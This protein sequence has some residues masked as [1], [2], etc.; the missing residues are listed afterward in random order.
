MA[1][2]IAD[3]YD[4]DATVLEPSEEEAARASERGLHVVL[5][6][7]EEL[8]PADKYDVVLLCQ[9][10]DHL[11]D[12]RG[13]LR[14]LRASL[15]EGGLFFMDVVLNGPLK[16]DHPF[17]LSEDACLLYLETAG[18]E[19]LTSGPAED[20]GHHYFICGGKCWRPQ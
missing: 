7:I 6:T 18:F 8:E 20:G 3:K 1:A 10:V 2:A 15:N 5:G 12:I 4:L 17:D 13:A 14:V 19:V 9:T 11:L 16:I